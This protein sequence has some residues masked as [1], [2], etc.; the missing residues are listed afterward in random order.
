MT[1]ALGLRG[2]GRSLRRGVPRLAQ[3]AAV[4]VALLGRC[5]HEARRSDTGE[6]THS[7]EHPRPPAGEALDV[8]H[9]VG[10]T[11]TFQIATDPLEAIRSLACQLSGVVVPFGLEVVAAAPERLAQRPHLR[12]DLRRTLVNLLA[13]LRRALLPKLGSFVRSRGCGLLHLGG[14]LFGEPVLLARLVH[15]VRHL[16]PPRWC[17]SRAGT[18]SG[19]G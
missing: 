11:D 19:R 5:L 12:A 14:C 17:L 1:T 8:A 13:K 18:R 2:A 9:D 10:A 16:T 6:K 15:R 3:R 4:V 7:R